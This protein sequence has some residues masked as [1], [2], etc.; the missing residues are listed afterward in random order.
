MNRELEVRTTEL[1]RLVDHLRPVTKA[2]MGEDEP[3]STK[4][5]KAERVKAIDA[6][7]MR[8]EQQQKRLEQL[9]RQ[10]EMSN[11]AKSQAVTSLRMQ[12]ERNKE[13]QQ[14]VDTLEQQLRDTQ[15]KL[16][17]SQRQVELLKGPRPEDD[18]EDPDKPKPLHMRL[19]QE[20]QK[21]EEK[22]E[23]IRKEA[24]VN[25]TYAPAID[26]TSA[27]MESRTESGRAAPK[28]GMGGATSMREFRELQKAAETKEVPEP[29]SVPEQPLVDSDVDD[30]DATKRLEASQ[31]ELATEKRKREAAEAAVLKAEMDAKASLARRAEVESLL[32]RMETKERD[33]TAELHA[34]LKAA[35][36][37]KS[38]LTLVRKLADAANH[39]A[40][41]KGEEAR[42][43]TRER[44]ACCLLYTSPSPR[45][46]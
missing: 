24:E 22:R 2:V 29:P 25:R 12:V 13:V 8:F 36:D 1:Q 15:G 34:A 41:Q 10:L 38:E 9:E 42:L 46:S 33:Q 11:K 4:L 30:R 37:A 14:K 7:V 18:D 43:L 3:L 26:P 32:Q 16:A 23:M 6:T 17:R 27:R 39:D 21:R 44:I 19:Q 40:A 5:T 45:D 20:Q 35:K 31:V 28:K